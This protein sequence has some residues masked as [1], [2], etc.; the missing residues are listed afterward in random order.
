[1]QVLK[2]SSD[3]NLEDYSSSRL[4]VALSV[5]AMQLFFLSAFTCVGNMTLLFLTT[6]RYDKNIVIKED[7]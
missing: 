5:T 3:F 7:E 6:C 4:H 2:Y 1:M